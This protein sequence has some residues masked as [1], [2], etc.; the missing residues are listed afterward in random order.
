MDMPTSPARLADVSRAPNALRPEWLVRCW[1]ELMP[2][3]QA[4]TMAALHA[5]VLA[6]VPGLVPAVKWGNL[7]YLRYGRVFATLTPHRQAVV[8]Q[9]VQQR[10]PRPWERVAATPC[11]R[12]R[13]GAEVDEAALAETLLRAERLQR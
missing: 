5:A 8:L 11:W 12:F 7:A 10:L 9:L 6:A 3:R 13:L 1:L 2:P 4:K